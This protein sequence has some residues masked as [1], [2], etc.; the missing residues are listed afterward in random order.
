ML[1]EN[2][3]TIEVNEDLSKI[4][5]LAGQ[6]LELP[7]LVDEAY[8]FRG[9]VGLLHEWSRD[10][11]QITAM[12]LQSGDFRSA[13]HG[14]GRSLARS[15]LSE[16]KAGTLLD[17]FV[18]L[19]PLSQMSS[20]ACSLIRALFWEGFSRGHE[21]RWQEQQSDV[22]KRAQIIRELADGVVV[23]FLSGHLEP[24]AISDVVEDLGHR[25]LR[26]DT[27]KI[28][29]DLKQLEDPNRYRAAEAFSVD[30]TARVLGIPC[31]FC[32]V[33]QGWKSAAQEAGLMDLSKYAMA[34]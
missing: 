11:R 20:K 16:T 10:G 6:W 29:V 22:W 15:G 23:L 26:N 19:L 3:A 9:A 1:P 14:V 30:A 8:H 17:V 31:V 25:L 12:E 4:A 21:E 2:A 5:H 28:V 27:R 18:E 13:V 24:E 32:G 33:S 34:F 7:A